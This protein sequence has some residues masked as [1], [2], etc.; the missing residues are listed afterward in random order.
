LAEQARCVA[1]KIEGQNAV[2][3]DVPVPDRHGPDH[4]KPGLVEYGDELIVKEI[5]SPD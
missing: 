3:V 2:H 4:Q 1:G 5:L